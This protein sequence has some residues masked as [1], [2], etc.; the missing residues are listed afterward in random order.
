MFCLLVTKHQGK[1]G[2]REIRI[3]YVHVLEA[4]TQEAIDD[5]L[6]DF[7]TSPDVECVGIKDL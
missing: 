4:S 5:A 3:K 1:H 6:L 2:I 7:L